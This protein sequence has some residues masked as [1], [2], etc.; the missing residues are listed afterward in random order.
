MTYRQIIAI[1]PGVRPLFNLFSREDRINNRIAELQQEF[2]AF[3][4]GVAATE[5]ALK[6]FNNHTIKHREL[7]GEHLSAIDIKQSKLTGRNEELGHQI[8][9]LEHAEKKNPEKKQSAQKARLADDHLLDD[10]YLQFENRFRGDEAT[11]KE[12]Q[13]LYLPYIKAARVI[14]KNVTSVLD[15]GCGRGEFLELIHGIA[16]T[17]IGLDLN[18]SMV[19]AVIKKGMQATQMD[20]YEFLLTQESNSLLAVTGFQIVEHIPFN[21]LVRILTECFRVLAPGGIIIFETPNPENLVVSGHTFRYDPSHLNPLP[22]NLLSFV[23]ETRGFEQI[24]I[25]RLH[26]VE[27]THEQSKDVLIEELAT[28]VYGPRDYSVVATKPL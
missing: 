24:R 8:A 16:L 19:E 11:I 12:R 25:I 7:L 2:K 21:E 9:L 6:E 15:I 23:V 5:V 26:P 4:T 17:P 10:F 22:P 14:N 3:Q 1:I 18:L 28:L 20:A 27:N 13:K